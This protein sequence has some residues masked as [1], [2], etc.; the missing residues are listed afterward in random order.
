[1][2]S[3]RP[4]T[5]DRNAE[6]LPG[7]VNICIGRRFKWGP[8]PGVTLEGGGGRSQPA[9]CSVSRRC[10]ISA[11]VGAVPAKGVSRAVADRP[12]VAPR[13]VKMTGSSC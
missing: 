4:L 12:P 2:F 1:M 6:I 10:Q 11:P 7:T 13:E 9:V 3:T 5:D 8:V